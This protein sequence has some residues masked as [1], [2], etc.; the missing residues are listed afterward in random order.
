MTTGQF[1]RLRLFSPKPNLIAF[2]QIAKVQPPVRTGREAFTLYGSRQ[3]FFSRL[4][5]M[6]LSVEEVQVCYGVCIPP[7]LE[8]ASRSNMIE[9]GFLPLDP[10]P[11][12]PTSPFRLVVNH[13]FPV[14]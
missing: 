9:F 12:P 2:R 6:T 5:V 7:V 10:F 4:L 3:S 8:C 1:P 14:Y 11:T 13:F